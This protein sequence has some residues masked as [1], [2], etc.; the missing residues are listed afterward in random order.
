MT[1]RSGAVSASR[2][3]GASARWRLATCSPS[4][5]RSRESFEPA[6]EPIGAGNDDW[7]IRLHEESALTVA[8]WGNH[9]G[10]LDR[11][12]SVRSILPDLHVLRLTKHG[13][14]QHPLYVPR[15]AVPL[16]WSQAKSP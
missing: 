14:P 2:G 10:F 9:G 4:E 5:H 6:A 13:E 15:D 16:S 1:R 11:S 12:S 7:L 8:A 3:L